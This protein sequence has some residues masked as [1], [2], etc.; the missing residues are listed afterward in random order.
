MEEFIESIKKNP[1][2]NS[3]IVN[4]LD[5][6]KINLIG[7]YRRLTVWVNFMRGH[8]VRSTMSTKTKQDSLAS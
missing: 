6:G 1:L 8:L 3:L 5:N 4:E 7:G 2:L